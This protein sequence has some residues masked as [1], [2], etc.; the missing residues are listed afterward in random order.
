MIPDYRA[1][2]VFVAVAD[3]ESFSGAGRQLKLSTSVV[4]HHIAKLEGKLGVSLFFRTSRRLS[5]TSEGQAVLDAAR[6][7]VA[8]GHEAVDALMTSSDNP[9]G[10]LRISVP[11][12]G[13][14]SPL[15]QAIWDFAKQFPSVDITVINSDHQVDLI[16]D[17]IDLAIRLGELHSSNLRC[18]KLADF[19]RDL[20]ASSDYLAARTPVTDID[21]LKACDF[22]AVSMLPKSITLCRNDETQTFDPANVSIEVDSIAAAKSAILAGLGVQ[23]LPFGEIKQLL[24]T[25]VLV[26][27]LPDWSLPQLGIYAVWPDTGPQKQLTRLFIDHFL[28]FARAAGGHLA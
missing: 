2:A 9:I 21:D 28:K 1:F 3:A 18:R 23:H 7:M 6:R 10:A 4:S 19:R 20:V 12:F 24:E 22:V 17:R 15:R 14:Q 11:A 16:K 13:E 5:L 26:R 8:A 25:G 27:V